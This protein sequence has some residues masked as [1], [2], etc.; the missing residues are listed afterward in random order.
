MLRGCIRPITC[1]F[2][3]RCRMFILVFIQTYCISNHLPC[4]HI[5]CNQDGRIYSFQLKLAFFVEGLKAWK[6][7]ILMSLQFVKYD[8]EENKSV[9]PWKIIQ[10]TEAP[11][12]VACF[13]WIATHEACLSQENLLRRGFNLC[14]W[15]FFCKENGEIV[16][17]L[18]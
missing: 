17:H 4:H 7:I 11:S 5:F 18:L 6:R 2:D 1:S 3:S 12:K 16:N 9:Y 13:G 15:C 10:K 14:R 8:L